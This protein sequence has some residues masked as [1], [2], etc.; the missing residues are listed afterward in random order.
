MMQYAK[1]K[2]KMIVFIPIEIAIKDAQIIS[3][4]LYSMIKMKSF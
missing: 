1:K 2:K 3:A 4:S